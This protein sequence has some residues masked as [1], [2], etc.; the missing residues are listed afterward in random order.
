[1][2][3]KKAAAIA[4][5]MLMILVFVKMNGDIASFIATVKAGDAVQAIGQPVYSEEEKRELYQAIVAEAETR[6]VAPIDARLDRVWF[7]IPGYNGLSI[8]IDK[9][10]EAALKAPRNSPIS[11]QY[12]EIAP[13]IQLSQL[14]PQPIY[15]GNP[16]KPMISLMIN[17]AWGNEYMDPILQTLQD[18][19][20]KATFFLDGSWLKK[21]VDVAKK[22]QEAGHELSNH[23]YSH[24]DMKSLSRSE[25]YNQIAKT[26]QLLKELLQV[27][28][29]WFAPPSGSYNAATVQI[30]RDQGLST[31]LW[32]IDT[33]DW[34]KPPADAVIRKI[35]SKLEPGSL[36]LMHPTA[37][38]RDALAGMIDSAFAKGYAIGTVSETLSSDRVIPRVEG[39]HV[40]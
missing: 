3:L 7:A 33:V 10:Y 31:V 20:V 26:E 1:M 18:K 23:A 24:P 16:E 27:E 25:Q 2:H 38:T 34:R 17:V 36:I 37:T 29:K 40:F 15:R 9:T 5:S 21:N 13:K 39:A 35:S 11:Y 30:A 28:N 14:G 4:A 8:D 22:I 19:G 32:T 6:S 12:K